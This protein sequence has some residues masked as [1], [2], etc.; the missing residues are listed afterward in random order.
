MRVALLASGRGS[1][2]AALLAAKASGRLTL[3]EFPLLLSNMVGAGAL[4]LTAPGLTT[5]AIPHAGLS[6]RKHEEAL[7]AELEAHKIDAL[8]L[9]GYMRVLTPFLIDRYAG[10]ILNIHPSLLPAFPGIDAQG[11]A[12]RHGVKI[13]GCTVHLVEEGVDSGPIILQ[14][15]V[16]VLDADTPETLAARILREEH[17][18]YPVALDLFTRGLL[19]VAGRRIVIT[20]PDVLAAPDVDV[21]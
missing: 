8:A 19:Q 4:E 7:L 9:C 11:Q 18:I 2:A 5:K 10:R 17:R 3:C 13:A 14:S 12:W 6:R 1:N 20:E 15:A 21:V 16:R